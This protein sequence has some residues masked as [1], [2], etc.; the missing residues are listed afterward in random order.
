VKL[1]Q[2]LKNESDMP[3]NEL[4]AEEAL[5]HLEVLQDL[6]KQTILDMQTQ[7]DAARAAKVELSVDECD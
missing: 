2:L 3:K 1:A 5:F 6:D 4:A 7:L